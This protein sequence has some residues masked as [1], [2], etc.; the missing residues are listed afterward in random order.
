M[1]APIL[2][3]LA[4]ELSGKAVIAKVNVDEN[5]DLAGEYGVSSIPTLLIFSDGK[6]VEKKVGLSTKD[7]LSDMLL[8]HSKG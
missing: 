3:E 7:A 4:E 8:K 1:Q 2:E 5:G 6:A